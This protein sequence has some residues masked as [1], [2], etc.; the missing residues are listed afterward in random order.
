MTRWFRAMVDRAVLYIPVFLMGAL[1]LTAYYLVR[2]TGNP[3]LS[4][5]ALEAPNAP[6][7]FMEGF[8]QSTFTAKGRL[9]SV[10]SG[11]QAKHFPDQDWTDI[12]QVKIQFINDKGIVTESSADHGLSNADGSEV[13]LIGNAVV[14]RKAQ[15]KGSANAVD[16]AQYKGE[17]LHAFGI[18]ETASSDKPVQITL[19]K[20]QFTAD[21]MQFDNVEQVLELSGRVKGVMVP[22]NSGKKEER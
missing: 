19:G 16:Y 4:L 3:D 14:E 6:D 17:Y 12:E 15:A 2:T 10:I 13:E 18:Q 5:D 1:A 7:Y 21:A 9:R 20:N 22:K 11:A 8:T